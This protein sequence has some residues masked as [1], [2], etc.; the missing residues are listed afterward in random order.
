M[1]QRKQAGLL[2][3]DQEQPALHNDSKERFRLLPLQQ[4]L[5]TQHVLLFLLLL[6]LF[7]YYFVRSTSSYETSIRLGNKVSSQLLET[8]QQNQYNKDTFQKD[9]K[10]D[11]RPTRKVYVDLGANCGNTYLQRK[12]KFE[13]E[14]GWE[15]YLWEPSPQ[16]HEFF[17]ND[18]AIQHPNINILPFAAGVGKNATIQLYIH[19][20]Q[21][22][23][24]DKNQFQD[25]GKCDPKSPYNPSGGTTMFS[26]AK[27]AGKPVN[28]TKV[29]FP[30][31]LDSLALRAGVDQF[32]FKIDIEGAE[33]DIMESLLSSPSDP[34]APICVAGLIEM[35]FH[36][37]IF[38]KGTKDY[39]KHETFENGFNDTFKAKCKRFP[40]LM[41][42]S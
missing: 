35:E 10:E 29:N 32:H 20:G 16:M 40:T 1:K 13:K 12:S 21:E 3:S 8:N 15:I 34:K 36:K 19:K 4:R 18:L 14:G 27:V 24:T 33:L 11:S 2:A 39:E 9:H 17:L 28:V 6:W 25:R 42:L 23:V 38:R 41:K 31:W 30:E 26:N 22:G 7:C 37:N 5:R